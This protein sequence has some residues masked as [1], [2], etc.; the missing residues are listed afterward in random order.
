M[1]EKDGEY[2][3]QV[4]KNRQDKIWSDMTGQPGG[5]ER[6]DNDEEEE[7][8]VTF[9]QATIIFFKQAE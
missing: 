7:E 2:I 8:K 4:Q 3:D 5:R 6:E 9:D 1:K